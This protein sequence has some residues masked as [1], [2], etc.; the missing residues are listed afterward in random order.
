MGELSSSPFIYHQNTSMSRIIDY[1]DY[2][3]LKNLLKGSEEDAN[4]AVTIIDNCSIE[5]S[6]PWII[7]LISQRSNKTYALSSVVCKSNNVCRYI[8]GLIG[9]KTPFKIEYNLDYLLGLLVL[10]EE[11]T[12]NKT[13]ASIKK[14]IIADYESLKT[15]KSLM[16][17]FKP[18]LK[19]KKDVRK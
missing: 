14:I 13:P 18:Q 12:N 9:E 1:K 8:A 10:H 16:Y 15:E 6:F 17:T 7:S 11:I 2:V 3:K 19:P 5:V 4:L